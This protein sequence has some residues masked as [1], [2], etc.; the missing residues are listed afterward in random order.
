MTQHCDRPAIFPFSNPT[1]KS[2]AIPADLLN[3]TDG[4]ALIATG[5]PFAPVTFGGHSI[6]V[7]QG[8]NV[9]VFPGVGLGALVAEAREVTDEM[10]AAAVVALAQC[11]TP[12]DLAAGMLY[13]ALR[14]LR[15]VTERVATAVA[16][17]AR[18]TG[19]GR[20]MTDDSI[21][22]AVVGAMW[23]PCYPRLI[24]AAAKPIG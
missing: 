8:N 19:V 2:E 23:V 4:R 6:R 9:Y 22:D 13:P 18:D 3:W 1:S 15:S 14:Q 20:P 12:E 10:F 5:S 17:A 11:T 7:A 24:V 16:K 21:R